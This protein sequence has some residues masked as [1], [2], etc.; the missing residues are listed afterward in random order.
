MS[1]A[2]HCASQQCANAMLLSAAEH[3]LLAHGAADN[4]EMLALARKA[5][6]FVSGW[7]CQTEMYVLGSSQEDIGAST[8]E[9]WAAGATARQQAQE[10]A[11]RPKLKLVDA[12]DSEPRFDD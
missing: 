5:A 6:A 12:T 9:A 2:P 3:W 11:V 4:P 10:E 8:K 7:L 1:D